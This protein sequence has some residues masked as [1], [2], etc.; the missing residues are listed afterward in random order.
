MRFEGRVLVA[1]GGASGL[2]ASVADRVTAE[3]GKVAIIDLDRE[4]AEAKAAEL[5]GAIGFGL[6]VRDEAAVEGAIAQTLQHFGRIDHVLNAAGHAV[7]GPLETWTLEDFEKMMSVHVSGTFLVCK[8]VIPALRESPAGSIVNIASVA[9]IRAQ[10]NNAPYGAAKA[11]I[12]SLSRQLA[13]QLAPGIRVNT[14][15]PG[16]TLTGMTAPLM[17]ERAGDLEA[18][19][20]MFGAANLQKRVAAAAEVAA[21]ICFLL[22]DE[23]SFMTGTLIVV[24]G[25]E[26]ITS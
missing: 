25:G 23:A 3:G 8:H 21:P 22:S 13:R 15:A 24:D 18:G 11:A 6:D 20:A 9:A 26:S 12:A 1:T 19:S 4:K 17:M 16:R 5:D 14:V 2:A 10:N 7:F